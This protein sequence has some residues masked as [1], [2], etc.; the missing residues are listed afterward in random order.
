MLMSV[1]NSNSSY[2]VGLILW[3]WW[4][5]RQSGV[6]R[7]RKK[8]NR[9][10][11]L[12]DKFPSVVELNVVK[13]SRQSTD[14]MRIGRTGS[15]SYGNTRC[16]WGPADEVCWRSSSAT[17]LHH[18]R[19]LAERWNSRTPHTRHNTCMQWHQPTWFG[20]ADNIVVL[21]LWKVVW[22]RPWQLWIGFCGVPVCCP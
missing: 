13:T 14:D 11:R 9:S 1:T 20:I 16:S 7:S 10:L 2:R 18:H 12:E 19:T 4:S 3:V 15:L 5:W 8:P 21:R 6:W 22:D 17:C